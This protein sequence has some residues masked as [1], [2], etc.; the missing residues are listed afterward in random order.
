MLSAADN[1]F[2]V[3]SGAGTPMGAL[4]RSYWLPAL[5]SEELPE[6]DGP[7]VKIRLLGEDLLAFRDTKGRVGI[8]DQVC[9]HR[10]A[11]LWM[12]RNEDCGIR[13]VYHGWKYDITGACVDMPTAEPGS[14]ARN[15]VR[16]KAYPAR[17][18]G[19]MVW[20][21][22]GPATDNLPEL[23]HL[24][25]AL[26]PPSHR[27]VS[28]KWQ[29]CNWV[30]A[31]E[32]SIDTA[33]FSF[34]H[35]TFEKKKGEPLDIAQHLAK[36]VKRLSADHTRWIAE[37]PRPRIEV[38]EHDAG[39]AIGGGRKADGDQTYWRVAQFLMPVHT[40][41]P[42]AVPGEY[43]FGQTFEPHSDTNCWIYTYV[44]HPDRPFTDEERAMFRAGHG[45]FATVDERY[46]PVRNKANDYLIDRD[47][48][49]TGNFTGI[50]GISE[51]DAA[52]QDSQGP[53]ADRSR[54]Y[55]G[56]TDRGIIQFRKYLMQAARDLEK[57][58]EPPTVCAADRYAV[59]AGAAVTA[60]SK[61]FEDVLADRFGAKAGTRLAAA[62]E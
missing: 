56:P 47:L 13:C 32:G 53:I 15:K 2:L 24:E 46:M 28:K 14:G 11:N 31:L 9:A 25:M 62:A 49:H 58:V 27:V 8:V 18:W 39:L 17:E 29:D 50:V 43:I 45:V 37:D 19:D 5:L 12:G 59:R 60:S 30:Q 48:Q 35:L 36:P 41:A 16:L 33:H 22:M 26:V 1:R 6:P 21:Y 34:A 3:E 55:L 61:S 44:W 57:G 52:V 51:Q 38:H 23:P 4:L 10:G 20:A 40:Y 7:P 42:N 54:E